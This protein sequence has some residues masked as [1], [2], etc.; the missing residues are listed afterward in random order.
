MRH[1]KNLL[2]ACPARS[3]ARLRL[4]DA[5]PRSVAARFNEETIVTRTWPLADR[6]V[7]IAEFHD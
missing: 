4:A 5:A 1:R 2:P 6:H 3:A 7:A